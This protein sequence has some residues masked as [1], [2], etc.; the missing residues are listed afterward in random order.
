MASDAPLRI[1]RPSRQIDA[2]HPSLRRE[3]HKLSAIR[4]A[5]RAWPTVASSFALVLIVL[6]SG[7]SS[8]ATPSCAASRRLS[9]SLRDGKKFCGV[10]VTHGDRSGLVEQYDVDVT[11]GLYCLAALCEN[12][13]CRARS[14]P[15]I[16]I[17]ASKA[18][19]VVG[20]RQTRSAIRVGT[21]VPRL[22][23]GS[24]RPR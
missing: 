6:P 16:P 13:C 18:P 22:F 8:A 9:W 10:S 2:T 11:G 24:V 1:F 7:V 19:I 3:R 20:I 12:V 21:S 4:N 15:A 23:R 5:K 17:A 14:I